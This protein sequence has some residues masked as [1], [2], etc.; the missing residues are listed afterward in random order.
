MTEGVLP[1]S[2]TAEQQPQKIPWRGLF[3]LPS[4][5][6]EMYE[7]AMRGSGFINHAPPPK[8]PYSLPVWYAGHGGYVP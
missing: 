8:V 7:D 5:A 4:G 1:V 3:G 6:F 2:G